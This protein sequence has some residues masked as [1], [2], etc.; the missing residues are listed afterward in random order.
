M[1]HGGKKFNYLIWYEDFSE[2]CAFCGDDDHSIEA[3]SLLSA[4]PKKVQIILEKAPARKSHTE[5][6]DAF[7]SAKVQH[8]FTAQK[9]M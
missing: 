6:H 4:P 2:G 1:R 7:S 9:H 8:E 5:E 3:C